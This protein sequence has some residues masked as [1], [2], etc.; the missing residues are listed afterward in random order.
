MEKGFELLDHTADAGIIAEGKDLRAT[1]TNAAAGM[2]SL[3]V[4]PAEVREVEHRDVEVT[5]A[6]TEALLVEWLNELVYVF[7]AEGFI[8]GRCDITQLT[9]TRLRA[10]VYGEKVNRARHRLKTGVKAA[11]YHR[12]KIWQNGR[13][14]ARVI[15]DV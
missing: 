7:D 13:T 6:D 12:L 8:T 11:T 10:R 1:F 2:L 14:R 4:E 5:A 15:F 9:P 3:F